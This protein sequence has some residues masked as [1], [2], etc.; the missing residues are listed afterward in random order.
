MGKAWGYSLPPGHWL[1]IESTSILQKP[2]QEGRHSNLRTAGEQMQPNPE[3]AVRMQM[4]SALPKT[5]NHTEIPE[6]PG[7]NHTVWPGDPGK[8]ETVDSLVQLP[9]MY[10]ETPS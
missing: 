6:S 4:H 8:S 10:L 3:A 2:W 1:N 9:S 7:L 5:V